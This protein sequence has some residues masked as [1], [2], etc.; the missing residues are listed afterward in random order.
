MKIKWKWKQGK[1]KV[2]E[3]IE[4]RGE[5]VPLRIIT[6]CLL[7]PLTHCFSSPKMNIASQLIQKNRN[8][9]S[10]HLSSL[11]L[12]QR[13][14]KHPC[15]PMPLCPCALPPS[16]GFHSSSP[17]LC[18]I[19]LSS[20]VGAFQSPWKHTLGKH[21][22]WEPVPHRLIAIYF[23]GTRNL[24]RPVVSACHSTSSRFSP[25]WSGFCPHHSMDTASSPCPDHSCACSSTSTY[26]LL[27][28]LTQQS[29]LATGTQF[30]SPNKTEMPANEGPLPITGAALVRDWQGLTCK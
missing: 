5:F 18:V 17:L 21:L 12:L 11:P 20:S 4:N 9:I 30:S 6:L 26:Q 14:W 27:H 3:E 25:P 16:Q 24:L 28:S 2:G 22:P 7:Q 29:F 13:E 8:C 10:L 15:K 23:L 1:E 19:S